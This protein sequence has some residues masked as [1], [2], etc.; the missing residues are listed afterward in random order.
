MQAILC[1]QG[2]VL[3]NRFCEAFAEQDGKLVG[4]QRPRALQHLPIFFNIAQGQQYQLGGRFVARE[5]AAILNDFPKARGALSISDLS[6]NPPLVCGFLNITGGKKYRSRQKAGER[7]NIAIGSDTPAW[8]HNNCP[9]HLLIRLCEGRHAISSHAA[10]SAEKWQEYLRARGKTKIA[11]VTSP[12]HE[13]TTSGV[14]GLGGTTS[15][16]SSPRCAGALNHS[17]G[18]TTC[19]SF[20]SSM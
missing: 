6:E 16:D 17:P 15:L 3:V 11:R 5:M 13:Q 1:G 18:G 14:Q 4:R 19:D 10:I 12:R 8:K 7:K 2:R 20:G 9:E